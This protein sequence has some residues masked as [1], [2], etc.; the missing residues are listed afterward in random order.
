[1][2]SLSCASAWL[3]AIGS[4]ATVHAL[5]EGGVRID[6]V[7][8]IRVTGIL[9]D[10]EDHNRPDRAFLEFTPTNQNFDTYIEIGGC[11]VGSAGNEPPAGRRPWS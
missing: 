4:A 3:I 2:C 5:E 7:G 8:G 9:F 6:Q 11:T 10:W 1:M